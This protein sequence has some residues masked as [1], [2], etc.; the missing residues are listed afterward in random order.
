M[1]ATNKRRTT[2]LSDELAKATW[3][4]TYADSDREDSKAFAWLAYTLLFLH[5]KKS[6]SHVWHVITN[7]EL[8]SHVL[9]WVIWHQVFVRSDRPGFQVL[10]L[11]HRL[12]CHRFHRGRKGRKANHFER[13]KLEHGETQGE[14]QRLQRWCRSEKTQKSQKGEVP[15]ERET[16]W[17]N[18]RDHQIKTK[19][20]NWPLSV[21]SLYKDLQVLQGQAGTV[22][23]TIVTQ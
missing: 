10:R 17:V 12:D 5:T 13:K 9:I 7:Y 2:Y 21:L 6:I 11:S 15:K 8:Q 22:L 20:F 18:I 3:I 1:I 4:I 19:G 14:T 16:R 23:S